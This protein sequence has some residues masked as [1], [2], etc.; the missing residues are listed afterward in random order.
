MK[1]GALIVV[2]IAIALVVYWTFGR[3]SGQQS[4]HYRLVTVEQGDLASVVSA[5]GHLEPVV[6]VQVGT[7][8]SG[9]I[10]VINVDFN[11]PVT[12]GQVIARI[13]TTLLAGAVVTSEANRQRARAELRHAEREHARI[14]SLWAEQL[15]AETQ[16]HAAVYALDVGRAAVAAAEADYARARQNLAYATITAP[17]DGTVISRAVDGG[18]TVQA[19]FSAPELFLIA[20]DLAQMQILAAVD[21]SD[22]GQISAGQAARFTV[23]AYP[24]DLFTGTVRQVR[25]RGNTAENVVTYTVVVDVDNPDGRLLPGMTATIDFLV[26]TAQDVMYVSNAAL[27]Y[28][29]SE[30]VMQAAMERRRAA[31]QASRAEAAQ[32]ADGQ[33]PDQQTAGA[34]GGAGQGGA[35]G[36]GARDRG[37][38]WLPRPDGQ[39]DVIMVRTGISDGIHTAV[40]GR[41]LEAGMQVIAG[42]SSQ[43]AAATAGSPFQPAGQQGPVR[44]VPGGF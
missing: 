40:Q 29:P 7:Q 38:L 36:P 30:A 41:E 42:I 24:D 39:V 12:A 27:R 6:T 5:T 17:I 20:N 14:S 3:G 34:G 26:E 9:I 25:L 18:Q 35:G 4:V 19:S 21:E 2:A 44:R 22:I 10:D 28:R 37:M 1:R 23:Q 13:D 15:V 8:V 32:A 33:R 16:Y 31:V 11:D 43:A